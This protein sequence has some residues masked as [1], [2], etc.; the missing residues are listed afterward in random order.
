MV[1]AAS[2]PVVTYVVPC[3]NHEDFVADTVHAIWAQTYGNTELVAIDDGSQDRSPR[4]LEELARQSPI[5]MTVVVRANRGLNKTLNEGLS[6]AK[7]EFLALCAS[8]DCVLPNHAQCLV[9]ALQPTPADRV[10][11]AYG[12]V[13]M[14]TYQGV[15]TGRR[16]L[17]GR[18]PRSGNIFDDII[19]RR[20]FPQ[21]SA[22]LYRVS[23]LREIG[24]FDERC[25]GEGLSLYLRMT[26]AFEAVY[27][28]RALSLYRLSD[29]GLNADLSGRQAEFLGLLEE[30]LP[31]GPGTFFERRS[32]KSAFLQSYARSFYSQRN[33][34]QSWVYLMQSVRSLPRLSQAEL[35]LRILAQAALRTMRKM[36]LKP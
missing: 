8:D 18:K 26:K 23:A 10:G 30:H 6:L 16:Q 4:I 2:P 14:M 32:I 25:R 28:D 3:Y 21:G 22:N 1:Q 34:R 17:A 24:G 27:V 7:G 29:A 33:L 9:D 5:P 20:Y 15:R 12:D 11:F 35:G 31:R 19:R 36:S 13:E